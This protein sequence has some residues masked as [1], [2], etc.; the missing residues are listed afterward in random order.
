MSGSIRCY[1]MRW[2]LEDYI[3]ERLPAAERRR[4]EKH[5]AG[6]KTCQVRTET[7]RRTA[8]LLIDYRNA[9]LYAPPPDWPDIRERVAARACPEKPQTTYRARTAAAS[10]LGCLAAATCLFARLAVP[11]PIPAQPIAPTEIGRADKPDRQT[12]PLQ[13][14]EREYPSLPFDRFGSTF[15]QAAGRSPSPAGSHRSRR[16]AHAAEALQPARYLCAPHSERHRYRTRL[17]G[18]RTRTITQIIPVRIQHVLIASQ[19]GQ[20]DSL[21]LTPAVLET[22]GLE[23]SSSGDEQMNSEMG[24][25]LY[26]ARSADGAR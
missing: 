22:P 12:A 15:E 19:A 2:R 17:A 16:A 23:P 20:E 13:G 11:G 10:L 14:A 7:L 4:I 6:C 1:R 3:A 21:V 24:R 9:P 5:L 18:W 25:A 26:P 8:T